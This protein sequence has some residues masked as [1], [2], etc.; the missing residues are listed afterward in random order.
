MGAPSVSAAWG[1]PFVLCSWRAHVRFA[2][3]PPRL[4]GD[5][6]TS[7]QHFFREL[8]RF[9]M[10]STV[11]AGA[12]G[13]A[14]PDDYKAIATLAARPRFPIRISNFLFPQKPGTELESFEKWTAEEKPNVNRAVSR[15]NGYVLEGAGE[16]LVWDASDFEN[17][18]EPRPELNEQVERELIAVTQVVARNQWPIRIHATYD[19]S[20]SRILDVFEPIFKETGYRARW[21]ID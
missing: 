10:T 14:W 13:V 7:T 4:A 19:E 11:D 6:L 1:G 18:M 16:I 12:T 5:R 8:N 21:G 9:G 2:T 20:I 15:L 17:F 3:L